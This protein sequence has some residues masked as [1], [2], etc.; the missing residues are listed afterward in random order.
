M[1]VGISLLTLVPG[2]VGGSETYARE[3]VRA[4]DRVGELEYRVFTPAIV[5]DIEGQRVRAYRASR[6]TP[7]RIVG[8]T[9]A[10]VAPGS[11]RKELRLDE[12]DAIHFP[13]T[14]MLPRVDRPPAAVSLLDI[15]HVFFP[16]FFSRAELL[17]RRFAYGWS[18][19]KARTVIAI[20]QHVKETLVERMEIKPE[21]VEVVYLGLDHELFRPG[22][23]TREPFLLYPAN[24]WP[25]KNH[26]RLFQAFERLR[27]DRPELRLVLTGTGLEKLVLPDGVAVKGRV[28]REELASLYR[29]A[30]ALVFPSLYEGFGQPPLEAMACGCPVACSTAGSLP[31]VCGNAARYFHPTSVDEMVEAISTVLDDPQPLVEHGLQRAALFTW[32]A[33][34]RGHDAVYRALAA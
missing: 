4:L 23:E 6:T 22:D 18:L 16:E 7:G 21:R 34:A 19:R 24:P 13:L 14:V 11:L 3:L 2:V 30:S 12:L 28:P 15:Q 8:M 26:A 32:E 10:A 1:R 29:R 25:H 5:D 27:R 17:Y 20:S 31:E 9:K 33:C